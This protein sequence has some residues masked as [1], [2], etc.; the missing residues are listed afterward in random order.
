VRQDDTG[1]VPGGTAHTLPCLGGAEHYALCT[2]LRV[3]FR[4]TRMGSH[5][6]RNEGPRPRQWNGAG[7]QSLGVIGI[8]QK[9]ANVP[10]ADTITAAA[11]GKIDV[12]MVLMIPVC[13]W[14]EDGREARTD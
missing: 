1:A 6:A 14:T 7:C 10:L 9:V 3:P 11:L 5:V 13:A 4:R 12:D 2:T 8:G